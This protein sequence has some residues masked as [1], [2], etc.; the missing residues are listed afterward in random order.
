V[1]VFHSSSKSKTLVDL[2]SFQPISGDSNV[3]FEDSPAEVYGTEI[4]LADR[5]VP[6]S[7]VVE[8]GAKPIE[9][10][11]DGDWLVVKVPPFAIQTSLVFRWS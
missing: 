10:V 2:V 6:R 1:Q 5:R 7:L 9:W 8:P 4:R 11:K 3:R